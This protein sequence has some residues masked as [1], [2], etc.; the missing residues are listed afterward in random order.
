[1]AAAPKITTYSIQKFSIFIPIAENILMDIAV[2]TP[3]PIRINPVI[4]K[5]SPL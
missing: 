5:N 1:M 4:T 3:P 2:S